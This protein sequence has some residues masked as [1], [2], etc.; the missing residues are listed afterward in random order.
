M[1]EDISE[2]TE[3]EDG[4]RSVIIADAKDWFLQSTIESVIAAGVE[5]GVTLTVGGSIVSGTLISGKTYFK[6]LGEVL[7]GASQEE[8]DMQSVLGSSWAKYSAIY[9]KPEDAPDDWRPGPVGF[10]HLRN[11]RY[12]APGQGALP[13]N[14]GVLWRGKLSAVDAFSIGSFSTD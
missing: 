7:A 9:E 2:D 11:A 4:V 10:I 14:Q 13:T 5:I 8:G 12:Y 1:A 6:E 3:N